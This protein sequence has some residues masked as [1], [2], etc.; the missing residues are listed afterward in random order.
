MGYYLGRQ[1]R[2][3]LQEKRA[4]LPLPPSELDQARA[5]IAELEALLSVATPPAEKDTPGRRPRA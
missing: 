2:N 3:A 5:R 4:T 1:F